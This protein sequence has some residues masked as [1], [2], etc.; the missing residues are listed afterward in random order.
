MRDLGLAWAEH[1]LFLG[2]FNLKCL[3]F[4][5]VRIKHWYTVIFITTTHLLTIKIG[6]IRLRVLIHSAWVWL[7]I[8]CWIGLV[9]KV[10]AW[11]AWCVQHFRIQLHIWLFLRHHL[12]V[13]YD[14]MALFILAMKAHWLLGW[15][16][17]Q[18]HL[19][20]NLVHIDSSSTPE[21]SSLSFCILA[22]SLNYR[23]STKRGLVLYMMPTRLLFLHNLNL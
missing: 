9:V 10:Y 21:N 3:T 5:G 15:R 19:L 12:S 1:S 6:Q 11:V 20:P 8:I 18:I 2:S 4:N 23:R 7:R 13:A 14:V 22:L 17:C 16:I